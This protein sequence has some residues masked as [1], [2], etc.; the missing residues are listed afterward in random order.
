MKI[1]SSHAQPLRKLV[2]FNLASHMSHKFNLDHLRKITSGFK[3]ILITPKSNIVCTL[4][5]Y[6]YRVRAIKICKGCR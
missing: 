3:M 2:C 1:F 5:N 4:K 6:F